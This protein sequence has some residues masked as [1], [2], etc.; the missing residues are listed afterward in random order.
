MM[1]WLNNDNNNNN[2][3]NTNNNNKESKN[4]TGDISYKPTHLMV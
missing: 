4:S 2:N 1:E 3:K